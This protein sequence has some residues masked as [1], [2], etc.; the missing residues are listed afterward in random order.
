MD[1]TDTAREHAPVVEEDT[2]QENFTLGALALYTAHVYG[3]GPSVGADTEPQDSTYWDP[4]DFWNVHRQELGH[5]GGRGI[6]NAEDFEQGMPKSLA[7]P[8]PEL[9]QNQW[10]TQ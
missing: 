6:Y 8:S 9:D 4:D 7:L 3:T 10:F 1:L 5:A 2:Y